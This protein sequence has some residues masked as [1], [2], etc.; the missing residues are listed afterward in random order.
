MRTV[1]HI[2]E[3]IRRLPAK[4]RRELLVVLRELTGNGR[5]NRRRKRTATITNPYK[6]PPADAMRERARTGRGKPLAKSERPGPYAMSLALAGTAH[7][8]YTDVS[9]DKYRHLAEIYADR[10]EDA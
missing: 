1:E 2:V 8:N 6:T 4:D 7:S 3:E 9:T 5:A 10:H